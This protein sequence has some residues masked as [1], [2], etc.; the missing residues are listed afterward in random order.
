MRK[1]TE[2][3]IMIEKGSNRGGRKKEG[4]NMIVVK[5]RMGNTIII[6]II[7]MISSSS[8]GEVTL[9]PSNEER[10]IDN[11]GM[12]NNSKGEIILARSISSR[13]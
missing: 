12:I 8:N 6:T 2:S 9:F 10:S 4:I 7:I 3:K 5:I 1:M 13:E 11:M